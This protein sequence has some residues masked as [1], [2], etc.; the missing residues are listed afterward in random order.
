[1]ECHLNVVNSLHGCTHSFGIY[2]HLGSS[3]RAGD[4]IIGLV[5][6][7]S[8]CPT[9]RA[10]NVQPARHGDLYRY[11]V[12]KFWLVEEVQ[13]ASTLLVRTRRGKRVRVALKRVPVRRARWWERLRLRDRFPAR[14]LDLAGHPGATVPERL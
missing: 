2:L 7:A 12:E 11:D 9:R 6:K 14:T 8:T 5:S 10:L 4:W 3:L 1:L 13:D